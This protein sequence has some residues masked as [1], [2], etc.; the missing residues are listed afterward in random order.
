MPPNIEP[1][2]K[3]IA[4]NTFFLYIRTF[5]IL[6][7]ALLSG[8]LSNAIGK[9]ITIELG[10]DDHDKLKKVFSTS[11]EVQ[12]ILAVAVVVIAELGGVWFLNAKIIPET[13]C[14]FA[15]VCHWS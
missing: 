12:V 7:V 5:V 4:K 14:G 10:C 2:N 11:V 8:S 15:P 6:I 9:Y 1:N 3:R 13:W